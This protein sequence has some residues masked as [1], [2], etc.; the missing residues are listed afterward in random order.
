MGLR[1]KLWA[2]LFWLRKWINLI[3]EV[4]PDVSVEK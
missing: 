2:E 4:T 3:Y 1:V